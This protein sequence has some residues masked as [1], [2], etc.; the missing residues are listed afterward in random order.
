MFS[1]S[2]TV[3]F[4]KAETKL[5]RYRESQTLAGQSKGAQRVGKQ[6]HC[7]VIADSEHS[8]GTGSLSRQRAPWGAREGLPAL[9][10][11][12]PLLPNSSAKENRGYPGAQVPGQLRHPDARHSPLTDVRLGCSQFLRAL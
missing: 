3:Y 5:V 9:L 6:N 8:L 7:L 1:T 4:K 12:V 11:L 2:C 10:P